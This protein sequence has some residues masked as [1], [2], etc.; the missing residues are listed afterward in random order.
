[1]DTSC[2]ILV[3]DDYAAMSRLL[4]RILQDMG[5]KEV[6][7]A[8]NGGVALEQLRVNEYGLVFSDLNMAPM[9]GLDLLQEVRSDPRLKSLPFIVVTGT[10]TSDEVSKARKGGANDYIVKPFTVDVVRKKVA[11]VL[12]AARDER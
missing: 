8:P 12:D 6:D 5:F 3:V 9:S 2:R 1:M 4:R 11:A 10:A 7:V